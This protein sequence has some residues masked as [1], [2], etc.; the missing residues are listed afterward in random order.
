MNILSFKVWR[1]FHCQFDKNPSWR[2][3]SDNRT[4]YLLLLWWNGEYLKSDFKNRI[5]IAPVLGHIGSPR[6]RV[7]IERSVIFVY[8]YKN[9]FIFFIF[10]YIDSVWDINN[11]NKEFLTTT[12]Q[13][14]YNNT[15][16]VIGNLWNDSFFCFVFLSRK[17]VEEAKVTFCFF[18][19]LYARFSRYL[20]IYLFCFFLLG[21][22][23][24]P[25]KSLVARLS[26]EY[27]RRWR[28]CTFHQHDIKH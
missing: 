8:L 2:Y 5:L 18:N 9:D 6:H 4:M 17:Q 19:I 7:F 27:L 1:I 28:Y 15:I 12:S 11:G 10:E 3:P 13:S 23:T 22:D 26:G 14:K 16:Y 25:E 21:L 20:Q 24:G